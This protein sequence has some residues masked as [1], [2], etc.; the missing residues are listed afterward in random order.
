MD[1]WMDGW[2]DGWMDRLQAVRCACVRA[3]VSVQIPINPSVKSPGGSRGCAGL[4]IYIIYYYCIYNVSL[5][6]ILINPSVKSP[7]GEN[8]GSLGAYSLALQALN[9]IYII[10]I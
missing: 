9:I 6:Q 4:Y 7:G 8:L 10:Y 5:W 1:R 3:C 2:M